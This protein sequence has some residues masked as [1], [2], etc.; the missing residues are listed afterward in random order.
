MGLGAEEITRPLSDVLQENRLKKYWGI[1]SEDQEITH[2]TKPLSLQ[3]IFCH[4]KLNTEGRVALE[5]RG[6]MKQWKIAGTKKIT[7]QHV[8]YRAGNTVNK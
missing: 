2:N 5:R 4:N 6:R 8:K 1:Q 3:K 7:I